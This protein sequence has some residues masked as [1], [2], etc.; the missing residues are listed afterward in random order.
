MKHTRKLLLAT[1]ALAVTAG[2]AAAGDIDI[3]GSAEMGVTGGSGGTETQFH[4]DVDVN[5][6]M[7]GETDGGLTFGT[8]VDLS[9]VSNDSGKGGPRDA[10]DKPID[11]ATD[12]DTNHGGV[13]VFLKGAFGELN[14]GDTDGGLDWAISEVPTG[15]GSIADNQEH[16]AWYG[17]HLDGGHDGQILRYDH[18]V[19]MGAGNVGFAASVEM[20]DTSDGTLCYTDPGTAIAAG[21]QKWVRA[22]SSDNGIAAPGEVMNY[23]VG[24][25]AKPTKSE[26][27]TDIAATSDT[28]ES[29]YCYTSGQGVASKAAQ[30]S[31]DPII[32]LGV[33]FEMPMAGGSALNFGIGYQ[34]GGSVHA[35]D[36]GA[37]RNKGVTLTAAG[38]TDG[39]IEDSN[40]GNF[41]QI[42][43]DGT[44]TPFANQAA[45]LTAAGSDRFLVAANPME[46]ELKSADKSEIGV[47]FG[48]A[49]GGFSFGVRASQISNAKARYMDPVSE[50]TNIAVRG[51][52]DDT[53]TTVE[54]QKTIE[55]R[56]TALGIRQDD[57]TPD[58][59]SDTGDHALAETFAGLGGNQ[60]HKVTTDG[61]VKFT[62]ATHLGI[63]ASYTAGAFTIGANYGIMNYDDEKVAMNAAGMGG[64]VKG[65]GL[66]LGQD[67]GGGAKALLGYGRTETGNAAAVSTWSAGL[68]FSF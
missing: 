53:S 55:T 44:R 10:D 20:D 43:A 9:D 30:E 25:E 42:A 57:T 54:A 16:G 17:S 35:W 60:L 15:P 47:S 33:K 51:E 3:S 21:T 23:P 62:D 22:N 19:S 14:L 34:G 66:S 37:T 38:L 63:G 28:N 68:S 32:A 13:A 26:A 6:K 27:G 41:V 49:T 12:S 24:M 5:F 11:A 59:T 2:A 50:A 64:D 61:G 58:L 29:Q 48:Y 40:A 52:P 46:R 45:I 1:T 36:Q 67:L 7:S 8:A 31:S 65:I 56:I 4:Q 39:G 18:T